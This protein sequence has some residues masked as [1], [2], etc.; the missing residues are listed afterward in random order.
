[1]I[2]LYIL[3]VLFPLKLYPVT[4]ISQFSGDNQLYKSGNVSQLSEIIH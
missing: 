3:F 2:A 1:M 4:L